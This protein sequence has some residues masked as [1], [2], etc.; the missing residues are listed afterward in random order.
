[1]KTKIL[2]QKNNDSRLISCVP[3]MYHRSM[4]DLDFFI[5]NT[6]SN[7][8][9]KLEPDEQV[10]LADKLLVS[11]DLSVAQKVEEERRYYYEL[12][13]RFVKTYGH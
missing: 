13:S 12:L 3:I 11:H 5:E 2:S 8:P 6:L 4:D 10:M 7:K 1:M 9:K